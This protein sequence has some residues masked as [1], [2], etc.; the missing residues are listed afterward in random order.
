MHAAGSNDGFAKSGIEQPHVLLDCIEIHADGPYYLHAIR[1]LKEGK[2]Q[3]L[4]IPHS[5]V[6]EIVGY[7]KESERPI[8]FG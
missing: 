3:T 4:W 5:A 6:V 8:G 2:T 7:A 1:D